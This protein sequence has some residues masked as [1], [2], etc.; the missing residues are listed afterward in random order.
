MK[1]MRI[2][3]LGI[4]PTGVTATSTDYDAWLPWSGGDCPVAPDRLVQIRLGIEEGFDEDQ[5]TRRG[6]T[7]R[8][9]HGE[10]CHNANI[11][12]YRLVPA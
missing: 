5:P 9:D 10:R 1:P 6:D 11:T 4:D 3:P 12:H 2:H 8:W 7:W